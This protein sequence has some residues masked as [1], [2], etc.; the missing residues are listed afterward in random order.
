MRDG[1]DGLR[2]DSRA[3]AAELGA[4]QVAAYDPPASAWTLARTQ[5][6]A[7]PDL[8]T[9]RAIGSSPADPPSKMAAADPGTRALADDV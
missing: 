5:I 7:G 8:H 1:A 3:V 6:L 2:G 9:V 4:L